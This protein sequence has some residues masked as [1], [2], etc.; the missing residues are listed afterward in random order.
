MFF[1]IYYIACFAY[2]LWK[3][4]GKYMDRAMPGGLGITPGLDLIAL[5]ILCW[6]LAPVDLAVSWIEKD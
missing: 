5:V 2:C 3:L 4:Y 1:W 6:V